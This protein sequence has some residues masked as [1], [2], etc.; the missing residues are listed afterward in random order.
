MPRSPWLL[1][2]CKGCRLIELSCAANCRD[3]G[4]RLVP[5]K[6]EWASPSHASDADIA[7]FDAVFRETKTAGLFD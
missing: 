3:C 5:F 2:C 4:R 6:A 7:R 1:K